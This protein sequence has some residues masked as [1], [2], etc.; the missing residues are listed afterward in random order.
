[1]A[2]TVTDAVVGIEVTEAGF[3]LQLPV[4]EISEQVRLIVPVN[5]LDAVT[6][7]GP[8]VAL[9]PAFTVGKEPVWLSAKS[10]PP[11]R[12]CSSAPARC[13]V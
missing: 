9:L 7:I 1:V 2:F 12:I 3:T 6:L 10:G 13:V 8:L 5:P 11:L 4:P